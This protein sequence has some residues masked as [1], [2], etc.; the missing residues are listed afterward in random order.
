[1]TAEHSEHIGIVRVN[2]KSDC[3]ADGSRGADV[4]AERGQGDVA[5]R[6][7]QRD[8]Y[9]QQHEQHVLE[10][11]EHAGHAAFFQ[12]GRADFIEQLLPEPH[13]A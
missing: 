4:F 10:V 6:V 2:Q 12:L 3:A 5:Q 9:Y 1:M 13:G 7:Q 8:N 11:G